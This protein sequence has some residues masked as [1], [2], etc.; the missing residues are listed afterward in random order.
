MSTS[1]LHTVGEVAELLRVS[2]RT[3]HNLVKTQKLIPT[4]IGDRVLVH[5]DE[6][7]RFAREGVRGLAAKPVD[8]AELAAY[9]IQ[10]EGPLRFV[11]DSLAASLDGKPF[12]VKLA[13]DAAMR[14]ATPLLK[15]AEMKRDNRH[16][17]TDSERLETRY[18]GLAIFRF[19]EVQAA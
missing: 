18:L 5:A 7:A 1:V 12:D 19:S 17:R 13:F 11:L 10:T 8:R 15:T 6:I 9:T 3:I 4:R 2:P 16:E 14:I